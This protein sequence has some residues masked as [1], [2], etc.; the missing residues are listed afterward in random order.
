MLRL[1]LLLQPP[2]RDLPKLP[3][4]IVLSSQRGNALELWLSCPDSVG[5]AQ[6]LLALSDAGCAIVAAGL[7]NGKV[8]SPLAL[9]DKPELAKA[10]PLLSGAL[11]VECLGKWTEKL[12]EVLSKCVELRWSAHEPNRLRLKTTGICAS[13]LFDKGLR[14]VEPFKAPP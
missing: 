4:T 2:L 5:L 9:L 13:E 12:L 7:L 8:V 14:L 3:C 1:S 11:T 10:D 6:T